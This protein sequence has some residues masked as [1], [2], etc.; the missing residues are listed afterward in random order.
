MLGI[1]LFCII[2]FGGFGLV[3]AARYFAQG[4]AQLD[5]GEKDRLTWE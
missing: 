2:F 1:W 3:L 5:L 4:A